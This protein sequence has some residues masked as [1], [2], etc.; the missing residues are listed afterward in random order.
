MTPEPP[1]QQFD[2]ADAFR[3]RQDKLRSDLG[4]ADIATHAS[5]KGDDTELN[6]RHMFEEFLPRRYTVSQAF[7]VNSNGV[8]SEQIDVVIHDRHF[9][10][11]LFEVGQATYIP[12]ES[13]YAAFEVKQQIDKENLEYAAQKVATVR[14]LDRTT[15]NIP[16]AGGTFDPVTPR[17][18][19][20][21][22]LARRSDWSPPFGDAFESCMRGVDALDPDGVKWGLDIGCAVADGSF[23]VDR[24]IDTAAAEAI[25]HCDSDVALTYFVMRLL[26]KLQILGSAAAIDYDAYLTSALGTAKTRE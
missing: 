24:N 25:H 21:G 18:I 14:S 6:W 10:P 5:T 7:V 15:T 8:R 26:R 2:L 4:M 11:Q 1:M 9:S 13:V 3:I 17:R 22:L 19:I 23:A 16:H 20:G 12:A